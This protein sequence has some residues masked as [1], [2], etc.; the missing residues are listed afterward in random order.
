LLV[1]KVESEEAI[2]GRLADDPSMNEVPTIKERRAL[3][4]L[5]SGPWSPLTRRV[6]HK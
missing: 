1:V 2:R 6:A 3:N 4:G 5:A